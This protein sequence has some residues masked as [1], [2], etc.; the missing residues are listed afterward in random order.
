MRALLVT[1][2]IAFQAP[3]PIFRFETDG[4]W[5]NMHHFLYVLGRAQNKA[6]DMQRRAVVNAPADQAK[7]LAGL[8]ESD[9]RAWEDAVAYYAS[10]LSKLDTVFDDPLID[11]TNAMR[12]GPEA[13]AAAL[14]VDDALRAT[15]VRASTAYRR[16]WWPRHSAENHARVGELSVQLD[17][18]GAKI[19][20]FITRAYQESWP[21]GGYPINM[22]GYT[23]WAGAY[24]TKGDLLVVSSL[25]EGTRGP[26]GLE[27]IFHEAMHQWDQQMMARLARVAKEHQTARPR[28]GI[29]H[30]LIWYTAAEA[31]KSVIPNH[32]GYAEGGGMWKQKGLGSFKAGLDAHWKPYLDGKG[33]LDEALL[34]LLK[35]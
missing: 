15:L 25:D 16:A 5:L 1:L 7:G 14:K 17:Q 35:S 34:G 27:I 11:V 23:N 4:F 28:D 30:A 2:L 32:V 18:H 13:T 21:K 20:A 8:S 26:L 3:A 22:S 6:P 31:V 9:R 24:S 19:L 29:T 33:T 10:G 12:V